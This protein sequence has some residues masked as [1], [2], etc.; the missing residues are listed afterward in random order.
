MILAYNERTGA[1]SIFTEC[2]PTN[3]PI[4]L[5]FLLHSDR[6]SPTRVTY[7]RKM[8]GISR[9]LIFM[10]H[11]LFSAWKRPSTSFFVKICNRIMQTNLKSPH[12][13]DGKKAIVHW[14]YSKAYLSCPIYN[15]IILE[16]GGLGVSTLSRREKMS[17]LDSPPGVAINAST[18]GCSFSFCSSD[19]GEFVKLRKNSNSF[20]WLWF[21]SFWITS[22]PTRALNQTGCNERACW[23]NQRSFTHL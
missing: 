14:F 5:T 19:D 12:M 21:L 13:N 18:F 11:T 10:R 3:N 20:G 15:L 1:L 16:S 9:I 17:P 7:E 22:Y 6:A 2:M 8:D 23:W 4:D